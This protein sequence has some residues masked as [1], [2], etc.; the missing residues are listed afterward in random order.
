MSISVPIPICR[1]MRT[2][3]PHAPSPPPSVEIRGFPRS[4]SHTLLRRP[5]Y[6]APFASI[7]T[8]PNI[9]VFAPAVQQ[10]SLP[11]IPSLLHLDLKHESKLSNNSRRIHCSHFPDIQAHRA[12]G[13]PSPRT[14][15]PFP[16]SRQLSRQTSRGIASETTILVGSLPSPRATSARVPSTTQALLTLL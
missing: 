8:R 13:L 15:S 10:W 4:A 7:P 9:D 3:V 12:G 11:H 6:S 14:S 1:E 2:T 16:Q 5:R